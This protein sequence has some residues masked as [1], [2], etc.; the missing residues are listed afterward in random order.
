MLRALRAE[1]IKLRTVRMN[2][3]LA[4]IAVAF[5]LI[6]S[7][8]T[9]ALADERDIR[10]ESLAE[11]V[12]GTSVITA[13]LLGVIGAATITGEF[14]FG[15]I[16]V[17]FAATPRRNVVIVAKA[18][19]T[20]VVA[21]VVEALVVVTAYGLSAAVASGRGADVDFADIDAGT[22]PFI[23]VIAFAAIV[24][25]LGFGL[26]LLIRNT[27]AAI[28]VLILWPLVA[29]SIL[30]GLLTV[31]GIDDAFRWLPYNA[32]IQM[33]NT[34]DFDDGFGR[35]GNGLYFFAVSAAVTALGAWVTNR[36]DA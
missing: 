24:A 32:G 29:E 12:T 1:F 2:W 14:G 7:L 22:A 30:G 3:V 8:L 31:A 19:A 13:M 18:I 36:R 20:V 5:P 28:A 17:T 34:T 10:A 15:T 25:L 23:G 21:L 9:A 26:G 11:V 6:V 35:F 33:A 4:I 16:R 27:P